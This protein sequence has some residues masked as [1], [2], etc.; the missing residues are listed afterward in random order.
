[1]AAIADTTGSDLV[2]EIFQ[3]T[4]LAHFSFILR[5]SIL[6]LFRWRNVKVS[7]WLNFLIEFESLV[8]PTVLCSTILCD[9]V[10]LMLILLAVVSLIVLCSINWHRRDKHAM[11]DKKFYHN[12]RDFIGFTI[13]SSFRSY[14]LLTTCICILAV[15]LP[16]FPVRFQKTE[17]FGF[18]LMDVGMGM[19]LFANGLA[20]N[21]ARDKKIRFGHLIKQF[22]VLLF[23]GTLRTVVL[24]LLQYPFEVKEYGRHWNF[25]FTLAMVKMIGDVIASTFHRL[26]TSAIAG[27]ITATM[28]E[29]LLQRTHLQQYALVDPQYRENGLLSQNREGI[30]SVLGCLSIFLIAADV[31]RLLHRYRRGKLDLRY[32][33]I[34]LF[35]FTIIFKL[36]SV[37]LDAVNLPVSRRIANAHYVAWIS[38]L[39]IADIFTLLPVVVLASLFYFRNGLHTNVLIEDFYFLYDGSLWQAINASGL[40]YF[41]LCNAFTGIVKMSTSSV[42]V[43]VE[44]SFGILFCYALGTSLFAR[45]QFGELEAARMRQR[46]GENPGRQCNEVDAA[47]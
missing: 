6:F 42:G 40:T 12:C 46:D 28:V 29:T 21:A 32:I 13:V 31:G 16:I 5:C 9:H 37:G 38:Y 8:M 3:F 25:F 23:L 15:D 20:S 17:S 34:A 10:T 36:F 33:A 1:M 43:G 18:S 47:S 14:V 35:S 41:L 2:I 26:Y 45:S 24:L 27:I 7:P 30:I 19:V 39:S 4:L 44:T 11:M 22:F